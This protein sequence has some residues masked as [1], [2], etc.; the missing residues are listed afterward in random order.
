MES[1]CPSGF[2]GLFYVMPLVQCLFHGKKLL[3]DVIALCNAV[4]A[5]RGVFQTI[6]SGASIVNYVKN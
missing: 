1:I 5:D 3:T 2:E 4:F 6:R